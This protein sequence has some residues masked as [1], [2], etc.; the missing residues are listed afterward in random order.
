M[1]IINFPKKFYDEFTVKLTDK[2]NIIHKGKS[3]IDEDNSFTVIIRYWLNLIPTSIGYNSYI[4][5]LFITTSYDGSLRLY[6]G[7]RARSK[8]FYERFLDEQS[9]GNYY[10]FGT[11]SPYKPSLFVYGSSKGEIGFNILTGRNTC[12]SVLKL[13]DVEGKMIK[14]VAF[15]PNEVNYKDYIAFIYEDG[16]V[17]VG[18]LS[19]AFSKVGNN[20]I[21]RMYKIVSKI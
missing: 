3:V 21:E 1:G 20:E 7:E 4:R 12:K 5:N 11:W 18:S 2:Y 8:F 15:N 14:K 9:E 10:S 13:N 19:E 17:E 6:H 16:T